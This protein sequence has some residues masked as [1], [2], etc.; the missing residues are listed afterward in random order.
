MNLLKTMLANKHTSLAAV[1]GFLT[2]AVP[3]FWP[4]L[5]PKCD[6]LFKLSII[7]GFALAG[8]AQKTPPPKT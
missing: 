2:Q 3:I 5:K 4:E 1:V 8:D 6:E 7:Y